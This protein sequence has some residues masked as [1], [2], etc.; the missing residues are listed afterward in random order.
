[1]EYLQHDHS[2]IR[3]VIR[4]RFPSVLP[5]AERHEPPLLSDDVLDQLI[6]GLSDR[7][8]EDSVRHWYRHWVSKPGYLAVLRTGGR[9]YDCYGF[10]GWVGPSPER[11]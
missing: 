8:G 4:H 11:E 1:M 7:F 9:T 5:A 6:Q 10:A 3:R 2:G